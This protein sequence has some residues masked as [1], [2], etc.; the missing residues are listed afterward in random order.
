MN[1]VFH[2]LAN[3]GWIDFDLVSYPICQSLLRQM[4]FWQKWLSS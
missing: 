1:T 4:E 2:Q 3:L